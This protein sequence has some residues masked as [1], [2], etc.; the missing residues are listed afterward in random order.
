VN[1]PLSRFRHTE[2]EYQ[3]PPTQPVKSAKSGFE[4]LFGC[5]S[6]ETPPAVTPPTIQ[7]AQ[8][9]EEQKQR[10]EINRQ[11]ALRRKLDKESGQ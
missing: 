9:T 10:I 2:I 6:P 7:R 3:T 11:S 5:R 1:T 4:K 8:L